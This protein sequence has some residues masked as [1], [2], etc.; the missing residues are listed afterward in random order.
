MRCKGTNKRAKN[1]G[2]GIFLLHFKPIRF[3]I[4]QC[5]KTK[6]M[7]S[8]YKSYGFGAQNLWFLHSKTMV[9]SH[10]CYFFV[11]TLYIPTPQLMFFEKNTAVQPISFTIK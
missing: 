7:L 2:N 9:L 6:P 11:N 8:P 1:K 5:Q 4:E 10:D 3:H